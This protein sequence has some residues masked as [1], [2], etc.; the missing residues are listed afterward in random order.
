MSRKKTPQQAV[1]EAFVK[2][3]RKR[4]QQYLEGL[5]TEVEIMGLLIKKAELTEKFKN[6]RR[7]KKGLKILKKQE[8][9]L[10][11]QRSDTESSVSK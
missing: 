2:E 5:R 4:D 8:D 11:K 10:A 9:E 3:Q 7:V 1:R 6:S